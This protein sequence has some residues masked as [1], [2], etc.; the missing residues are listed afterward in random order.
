VQFYYAIGRQNHE[1]RSIPVSKNSKFGVTDLDFEEVLSI[2]APAERIKVI[3]LHCHL[4]STILDVDIYTKLFASLEK[5]VRAKP[6]N[7]ALD[8]VRIIN[9]GG[10]LGINY[11]HEADKVSI[12]NRLSTPE[13]TA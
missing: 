1:I 8:H 7:G 3:G 9:V 10:G 4:G 11:Y 6:D 5:A 12:S 2:L 13:G